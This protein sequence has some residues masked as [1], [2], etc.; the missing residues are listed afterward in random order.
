MHST[1][2]PYNTERAILKI[3]EA[4][5][6]PHIFS[7]GRGNERKETVEFGATLPIPALSLKGVLPSPLA[8]RPSCSDPFG[9]LVFIQFTSLLLLKLGL[10][11]R[12][13]F[14]PMSVHLEIRPMYLTDRYSSE[15]K[16]LLW[17]LGLKRHH[18]LKTENIYI[19][20][21]TLS[22]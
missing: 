1:P 4:K 14:Q 12:T 22:R 8:F 16:T 15:T 10:I 6:D 2:K 17:R 7:F 18:S 19:P 9:V 21:N 20:T 3:W 13:C 11:R 5:T